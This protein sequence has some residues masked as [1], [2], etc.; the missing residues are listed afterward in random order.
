MGKR[1]VKPQEFA[2]IK[3]SADLVAAARRDA[4]VFQRS[5]S[6]QVEHWARLGQAI[7]AAPG[8]TLDRVRAAL[9]GKFHVDA[10]TAE[11]RVYF[12]D[13]LSDALEQ[14][15]REIDERMQK[16]GRAAVG[17]D[18]SGRLVRGR[19]DGSVESLEE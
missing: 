17:L 15:L 3:L 18:D 1:D 7:E 13:L 8:F 19:P 4:G 14:L 10:L 2:S 11:E 9:A 16:I 6:G 12:D 5:V